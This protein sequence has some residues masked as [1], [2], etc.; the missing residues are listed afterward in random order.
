MEI[1]KYIQNIIDKY[2]EYKK[3]YSKNLS[4]DQTII[5]A[6]KVFNEL[7]DG[8]ITIGGKEYTIMNLK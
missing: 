3:E 4:T 6:K 1:H 8:Q 7:N 5:D 2:E